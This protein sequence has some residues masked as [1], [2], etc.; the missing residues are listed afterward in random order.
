MVMNG[1]FTGNSYEGVKKQA[2]MTN[3]PTPP[4]RTFF[5]CQKQVLTDV[6]NTVKESCKQNAD[7]I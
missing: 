7:N 1:L 4:K 6:I 5:N 3:T 2:A